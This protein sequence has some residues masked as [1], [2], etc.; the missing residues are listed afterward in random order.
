M[1]QGWPHQVVDCIHEAGMELR[2]PHQARPL[3]AA[4][5][6]PG[7]PA[8]ALTCTHRHCV[9]EIGREAPSLAIYD[10]LG[11]LLSPSET[12]PCAHTVAASHPRLCIE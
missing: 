4:L 7:V 8:A 5:C 2:C 6:S 9:A 1:E 3:V 12:S 11:G 10:H